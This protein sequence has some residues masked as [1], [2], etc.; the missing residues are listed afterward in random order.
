MALNFLD[1]NLFIGE[2]VY[3]FIEDGKTI[4]TKEPIKIRTSLSKQE[5]APIIEKKYKEINNAIGCYVQLYTRSE[6]VDE[7][8]GKFEDIP[9]DSI[10]VSEATEYYIT[11]AHSILNHLGVMRLRTKLSR[12]D[13]KK[14]VHK[15]YED[16]VI[17]HG[18]E[19]YIQISSKDEYFKGAEENYYSL[20]IVELADEKEGR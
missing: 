11:I 10:E 3:T 17:E 14:F 19:L 12:P 16:V 5:V 9:L 2:A 1:N 8:F 18:G 6:Y 13:I 15:E 7:C 20:G 4:Q